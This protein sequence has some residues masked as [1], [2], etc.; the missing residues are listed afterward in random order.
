MLDSVK[1]RPAVRGGPCQNVRRAPTIRQAPL[2]TIALPTTYSCWSDYGRLGCSV[3]AL[4]P[5]SG[6]ACGSRAYGFLGHQSER[7]F[8][9]A[10]DGRHKWGH[11]LGCDSSAEMGSKGPMESAAFERGARPKAYT[12]QDA[13]GNTGDSGRFP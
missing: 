13:H 10:G 3:R 7:C 11:D 1:L 8:F 12:F 5:D 9:G 6:L 2:L 4:A